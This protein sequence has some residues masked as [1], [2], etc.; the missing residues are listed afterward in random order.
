MKSIPRTVPLSLLLAGLIIL[1]ALPVLAQDEPASNDQIL[2][3]KMRADKKLIVASNMDLT[4]NEAKVF[5]PVY[6]E[7]QDQLFLLR[8]RIGRWLNDY[9]K[10]YDEMSNGD[11]KKL[12]DESVNIDTLTLKLRKRYIPKFRQVLPEKKA[13]RYFQ[14]E[15]KIQAAL[16]Y[17]LATQIP[18]LPGAEE[19]MKVSRDLK[20]RL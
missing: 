12:L 9:M 17:E 7:Y 16:D 8:I 14:I 18:L 5:W 19:K 20:A 1:G 3:E 10:A 2:L 11:A 4:E 13:T 15:S 6:D